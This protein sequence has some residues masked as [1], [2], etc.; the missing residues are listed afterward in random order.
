[1]SYFLFNSGQ[2]QRSI[3]ADLLSFHKVSADYEGKAVFSLR[4]WGRWWSVR[5]Q[6]LQLG[7]YFNGASE[8]VLN[9]ND[10]AC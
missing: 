2:V 10:A 5:K 3:A 1:M 7:N 8:G 9:K 6:R 4:G